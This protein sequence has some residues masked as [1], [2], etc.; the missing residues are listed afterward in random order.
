MTD[1]DEEDR[2]YFGLEI[3]QDREI[4]RLQELHRRNA[5]DIRRF[6]SATI[7]DTEFAEEV[8]KLLNKIENRSKAAI[9]DTKET[10]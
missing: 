5:L 2:R 6:L 8:D 1:F 3:E 10:G 4:E 9:T 7:Y